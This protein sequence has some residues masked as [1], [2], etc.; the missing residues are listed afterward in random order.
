MKKTIK[1]I[2]LSLAT[3]A[4]LTTSSHALFGIG[5]IVFD[6]IQ[7]SEVVEIP[8]KFIKKDFK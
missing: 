6:P 4:I 1:R 2:G 8:K 5:D 7:T 3:L